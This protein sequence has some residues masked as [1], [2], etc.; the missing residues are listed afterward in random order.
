MMTRQSSSQRG[1]GSEDHPLQLNRKTCRTRQLL[2][3]REIQARNQ[4]SIRKITIWTGTARSRRLD[5]LVQAH[6]GKPASHPRDGLL[7]PYRRLRR[8]RMNRPRP[9]QS[10]PRSTLVT[11]QARISASLGQDLSCRGLTI[12]RPCSPTLRT[13]PRAQVLRIPRMLR[14]RRRPSTKRLGNDLGRLQQDKLRRRGSDG[15]E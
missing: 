13:L 3:R 11:N 9:V 1:E 15:P 2:S 14:R 10:P 8:Y 7:E 5:L 12:R 6:P 4:V